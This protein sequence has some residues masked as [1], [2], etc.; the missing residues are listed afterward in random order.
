MVRPPRDDD[1]EWS[2]ATDRG[3]PTVVGMQAISPPRSNRHLGQLVGGTLLGAILVAVG[4]TF[5]LLVIET[6]LVSR[7][8]PLRSA[9]PNQTSIAML[10]WALALVA[11][12]SLLVAGTNRLA[13]AV[14]SVRIRSA[15]RSPIIRALGR[16][17]AD[18]VV[19]TGVVLGD[20]RPMPDLVIGAFGV[21]VVHALAAEDRIRRV[22]SSWETK[23]RDGWIPSEYP[24]DRVARDAERVR[25][26][27]LQGDLDFV[28]RVYA[29][30]V[31]ADPTIPRSPVCAVITEDQ[32]P[33]WLAALPRQR[34]LSAGRR[35]RLLA[36]VRGAAVVETSRRGW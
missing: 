31:T 20:G 17:P 19:A 30:L 6:P 16:L 36:R 21:A 26:W 22:G 34:S 15:E 24:V 28:V 14:A 1:P 25:H 7:L 8:V 23:T 11:G 35:H 2:L 3:G 12:G 4:L 27:L 13:W 18:A 5:A 32:I 9:G 33:A 10:V 29:A